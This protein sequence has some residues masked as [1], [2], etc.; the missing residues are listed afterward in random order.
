[1]DE[2]VGFRLCL[3]VL[4]PAMVVENHVVY[5]S[6]MLVVAD[7]RRAQR[8]NFHMNLDRVMRANSP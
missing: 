1:M 3:L 4:Q 8:T 2:G 7:T 5:A 6:D